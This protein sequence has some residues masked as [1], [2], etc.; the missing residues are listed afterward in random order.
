MFSS[1][2]IILLQDL[3]IIASIVTV[4]YLTDLRLALIVSITFP[5]FLAVVLLFRS[6]AR[7]AYRMIRTR[8]AD[9]NSFSMK[10]SP[11]CG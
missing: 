1:V 3:L 6:C 8:I 4:M 2:L 7:K 5:R 10:T 11:I 9:L